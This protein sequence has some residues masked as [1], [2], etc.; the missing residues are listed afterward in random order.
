MQAN[1]IFPLSSCSR[2]TVSQQVSKSP[3]RVKRADWVLTIRKPKEQRVGGNNSFLL[4]WKEGKMKIKVFPFPL[5]SPGL[6]TTEADDPKSCS[7]MP[8]ISRATRIRHHDSREDRWRRGVVGG[9]PRECET[10]R[11]K[12]AK[13]GVR[14][15]KSGFTLIKNH[16]VP[17]QACT[18]HR[19]H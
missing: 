14:A 4:F 17:D 18:H 5:S 1:R 3:L 12:E 19:A 10:E 8:G 2:D 7:G 13:R 11:Q 16:T 6:S 15:I 9:K